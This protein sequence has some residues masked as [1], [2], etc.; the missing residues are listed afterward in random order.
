MCIQETKK[1]E[2]ILEIV[3]QLWEGRW[4][5]HAFL[6]VSEKEGEFSL[7]GMRGSGRG[8]SGNRNLYY[9]L[10]ICI[11]T[12]KLFVPYNLS[13]SSNFYKEMRLVGKK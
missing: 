1:E 9:L 10:Y 2:D 8:D 12:I 13:N 11:P 6:D 7:C 4:I 3:Q 5:R